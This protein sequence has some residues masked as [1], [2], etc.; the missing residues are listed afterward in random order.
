[1]LEKQGKVVLTDQ[2][3]QEYN[4]GSV[5]DRVKRTWDLSLDELREVVESRQYITINTKE[6]K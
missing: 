4:K 3:L 2:D 1:M 6:V 5:S